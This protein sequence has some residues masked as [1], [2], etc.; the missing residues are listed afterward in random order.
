MPFECCLNAV[1]IVFKTI[2]YFYSLLLAGITF[3]NL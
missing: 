1:K 2:S 3:F